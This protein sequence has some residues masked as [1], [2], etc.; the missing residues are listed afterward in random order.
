MQTTSKACLLLLTALACQ[1]GW[2]ADAADDYGLYTRLT[3]LSFSNGDTLAHTYDDA[4]AGSADGGDLVFTHNRIELGV[5]KGDW[6][7]GAFWRTDYRLDFNDDTAQFLHQQ[8][9][10]VAVTPGRHYGLQVEGN[11][12]TAMGLVVGKRFYAGRWRVDATLHLLRA[13]DMLDGRVGAQLTINDPAR[14]DALEFAGT[15]RV[16]YA[17]NKD[18]LLDRPRAFDGAGYGVGFDL[19]VSA[20]LNEHWHVSAHLEDAPTLIYWRQLPFTD[21]N[22]TLARPR[23]SADG[24]LDTQP[25]ASGREYKRSHLQRLPMRYTAA[26]ARSLSPELAAFARV[27]GFATELFPQLGLRWQ[28]SPRWQVALSV[29]LRAHALVLGVSSANTRAEIA[30]DDARPGRAHMASAVLKVATS[31]S[32]VFRE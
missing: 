29:D 31:E 3:T 25:L 7:I 20:Q 9:D 32:A 26:A 11:H 5:A 23:F 16:N 19:S 13:T 27:Q 2:A 18:E 14:R 12:V 8:H 4:R 22:L 30:L 28:A 21:V 6:H 17:Y 15:G 10:H 24:T 1:G